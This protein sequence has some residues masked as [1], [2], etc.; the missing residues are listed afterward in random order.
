MTGA[1]GAMLNCSVRFCP[2]RLS[3]L[4]KLVHV[5]LSRPPLEICL[6][7]K[8][9]VTLNLVSGAIVFYKP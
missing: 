5:R 9:T 3:D 8:S 6:R 7:V 1:N 2:G 4:C